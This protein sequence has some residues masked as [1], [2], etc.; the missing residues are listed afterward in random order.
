LYFYG[1]LVPNVDLESLDLH[2]QFGENANTHIIK[3]KN[4]VYYS[5]WYDLHIITGAD[6][7]TFTGITYHYDYP[8]GTSSEV[9]LR[10]YYQ[11]KNHMYRTDTPMPNVDKASFQAL[12]T[13]Y[14]YGKASY[15]RDK[16]Q[17]YA[18]A[19]IITG[20]DV[21]TFRIV[22]G[23]QRFDAMDKKGFYRGGE[24]IE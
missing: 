4:T 3:D 19:N 2:V 7:K 22:W 6:S 24:K 12:W 23:I 10:N 17:V 14:A 8:D 20:A 18:N 5:T 13:A 21:K 15:S 11:D 16:T 1:K 9:T